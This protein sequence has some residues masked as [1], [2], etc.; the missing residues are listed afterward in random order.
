MLRKLSNAI[1]TLAPRTASIVKDRLLKD[2]TF[3]EIAEELG[4]SQMRVIQLYKEGIK[5]LRELMLVGED[6]VPVNRGRHAKLSWTEDQ[7]E[8]TRQELTDDER[9]CVVGSVWNYPESN[10]WAAALYATP[11]LK[12]KGL[13]SYSNKAL[14]KAAVNR[15]TLNHTPD[16]EIVEK[17]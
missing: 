9:G 5:N 4:I 16:A 8:H 13:G 15:A 14:A 1:T 3:M 11:T 17:A 10:R 7:D 6:I 12:A 2:F